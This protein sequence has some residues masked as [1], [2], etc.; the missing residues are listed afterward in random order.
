MNT[1]TDSEMLE[2][3]GAS[4]RGSSSDLVKPGIYF[5]KPKEISPGKFMYFIPYN[6]WTIQHFWIRGEEEPTM[7][8]VV[9]LTLNSM[10]SSQADI[11][12]HF[13][14]NVFTI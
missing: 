3:E 8:S 14:R 13:T 11:L 9:N 5:L 1:V 12:T 2:E 4:E 7:V 6:K 10:F